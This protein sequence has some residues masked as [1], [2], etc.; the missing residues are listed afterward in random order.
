MARIL[1][2]AYST[3]VRDAR[4]RRHAEA[5]VR[6]GDE[7]DVLC[8]PPDQPS[9]LKGVNLHPVAARY[10][11]T[12]RIRYLTSYLHFFALAALVAMRRTLKR[13]YDLVIVCTMPDAAVLCA[14]FPKVLGAKVLLDVHDTMPELY[15][16]K[17]GG[18]LGS[19]AFRLLLFE[20]RAS[21]WF[22]DRVLAVHDLHARRLEGAGI[23]KNKITV[24]VNVPDPHIFN[25]AG[26]SSVDSR[27]EEPD[28]NRAPSD[29]IFHGTLASRSGLDVAL[30]SICLVRKTIPTV[31]LRIVGI[32][33]YAKRLRELSVELG[34]EQNVSFE[35]VV[36]VEK[37]PTLLQGATVGLIPNRASAATH[38]MLPVKLLEYAI[39][40]IPVVAARLKTVEYYF[41]ESAVRY[42]TPD[43]PVSLAEAIEDLLRNPRRRRQLADRAYE[44]ARKLRQS[45]SGRFLATIDSLVQGRRDQR[46][47]SA[48]AT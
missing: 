40:R 15:Q 10:L 20:E 24:V 42:F 17:F 45:Q 12:S 41:D 1:I 7:V 47:R 39:M 27:Q 19:V 46:S 14:V 30:E 48:Q 31:H 33:D 4:I 44:I 9:D 3:Y 26:K 2:I 16:E 13:R 23:D 32:G 22:A 18:A 8:L 25:P 36:P 37:L 34:I 5:L 29:L 28:G 11:G 6:R 21:A 35:D 43:D 38:L